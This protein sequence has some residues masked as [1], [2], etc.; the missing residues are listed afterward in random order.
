[1]LAVLLAGLAVLIPMYRRQVAIDRLAALGHPIF[2][3]VERA[4]GTRIGIGDFYVVL[5]E[6]IVKVDLSRVLDRPQDL[7]DYLSDFRQIPELTV[8]DLSHNPVTDSHLRHL[9]PLKALENLSLCGTSISDDGLGELKRFT[10]LKEL[11]LS[12]TKVTDAGLGALAGLTQLESLALN[13]TQITDAGLE[14][15]K[16]LH[17]LKTL[18]VNQTSVTDAGIRM[19]TDTLPKLTI[20]D[21]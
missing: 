17:R 7:E 9:L 4:P 20:L 15:L 18:E 12:Q 11:N 8:V 14:H 5:G 13:E 10:Y 19:L 2:L 16:G 21:D 1:M 3:S 6:R